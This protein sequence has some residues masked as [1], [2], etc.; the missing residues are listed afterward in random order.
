MNYV[1]YLFDQHAISVAGK[2][3][4]NPETEADWQREKASLGSWGR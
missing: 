1:E 4:P 3:K 2:E